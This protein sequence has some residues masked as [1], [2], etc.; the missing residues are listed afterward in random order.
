MTKKNNSPSHTI[1]EKNDPDRETKILN[2]LCNTS[3]VLMTM[4]TEAVSQ[5]F[6]SLTKEMVNALS[7][8]VDASQDASTN[9]DA[10]EKNIPEKFRAEMM[11]MKNDLQKQLNEKKQQL[12]GL[13]SDPRFDTGIAIAERASIPLPKLTQDLD[14]RSLYGYLALLQTEDPTV[15]AMFKELFEWMNTLPKFDNKEG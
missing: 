9:L 14:E 6:T 3:L 10:L 8:S 1:R 15:S 12:T 2:L 5:A 4:L 13:L 7:T 11:T